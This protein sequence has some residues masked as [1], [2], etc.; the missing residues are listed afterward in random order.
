MDRIPA[1]KPRVIR[2]VIKR[3]S[4][5]P[6]G[7]PKVAVDRRTQI[8]VE[9]IKAGTPHKC[10][11]ETCMAGPIDAG[12]YY[13]EVVAPGH[14]FYLGRRLIPKPTKYHHWCLPVEA[15]PLLRFFQP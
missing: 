11:R 12:D 8:R 1:G 6:V 2:K 10:Q 7:R 5:S 3:W 4:N 14:G 13:F 15:R 9:Q